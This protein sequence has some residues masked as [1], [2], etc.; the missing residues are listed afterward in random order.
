[1]KRN[2]RKKAHRAAKN[3]ID[4]TG[5]IKHD[6]S[7]CIL[8]D[9]FFESQ[10]YNQLY[11]DQQIFISDRQMCHDIQKSCEICIR[12]SRQAIQKHE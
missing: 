5:N 10:W 11:T 4:H 7:T 8:V 2:K 3:K 6:K 1:M 9:I 12:T